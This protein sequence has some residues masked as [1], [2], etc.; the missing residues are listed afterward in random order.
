MLSKKPVP[1]PTDFFLDGL[2]VKLWIGL[3]CGRAGVGPAATRTQYELGRTQLTRGGVLGAGA[4]AVPLSADSEQCR[5]AG[6]GRGRR[7]ALEAATVR[8]RDVSSGAR[9]ASRRA[10]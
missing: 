6:T 7:R 3:P 10:F 2:S 1:M 4:A 8:S 9:S 5:P